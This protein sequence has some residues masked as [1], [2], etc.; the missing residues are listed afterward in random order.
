[1]AHIPF[2]YVP[3]LT[4]VVNFQYIQCISAAISL[5]GLLILCVAIAQWALMLKVKF[6][7]KFAIVRIPIIIIV[8]SHF[9]PSVIGSVSKV[10]HLH[11]LL[12]Y[13]GG[14]FYLFDLLFLIAFV[15]DVVIDAKVFITVSPFEFPINQAC[16]G[17]K[18][19]I[20][21]AYFS[22]NFIVECGQ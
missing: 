6:K 20:S 1:M 13:I 18:P 4:R 7:H 15:F 11:N 19:V 14:V 9:L 10:F 21:F 8:G 17:V 5:R 12:Q 22:A 16:V 2:N 3:I